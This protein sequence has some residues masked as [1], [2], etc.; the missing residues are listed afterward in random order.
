MVQKVLLLLET[1]CCK[2]NIK[3]GPAFL[4]CRIV[5]CLMLLD[6]I[7]VDTLPLDITRTHS[8]G[9]NSLKIGELVKLLVMSRSR[10]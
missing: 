5:I 8:V 7:G 2:S 1:Q 9:R 6:S 3:M 4:V 10:R